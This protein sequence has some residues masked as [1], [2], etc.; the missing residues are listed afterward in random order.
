MAS[1]EGDRMT[2]EELIGQMSYVST[3]I[4]YLSVTIDVLSVSS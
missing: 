3:T 4:F 2:E 1:A